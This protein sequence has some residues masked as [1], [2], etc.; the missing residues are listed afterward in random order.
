MNTIRPAAVVI[1]VLLAVVKAHAASPPGPIPGALPPRL[2]RV[3]AELSIDDAQRAAVRELLHD[4]RARHARDRDADR[5][6]LR[7]LLSNDQAVAVEAALPPPGGPRCAPPDGPR[8][9]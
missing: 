3:L 9:R 8:M 6:A 1:G 2:E 4:R 7:K 5:A